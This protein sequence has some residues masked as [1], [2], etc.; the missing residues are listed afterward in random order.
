MCTQL[1]EQ[2]QVYSENCDT[3]L[4]IVFHLLLYIIYY[5]NQLQFGNCN[6]ALKY[7]A[8]LIVM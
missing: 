1:L 2:R 6:H 7:K 3:T 8:L 4:K 5:G